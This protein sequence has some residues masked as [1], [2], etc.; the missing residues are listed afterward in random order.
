[1][2]FIVTVGICHLPIG[3]NLNA[4]QKFMSIDGFSESKA[5]QHATDLALEEIGG[6]DL[7]R[8]YAK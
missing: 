8:L 4:E 7:E 2:G 3:Y 5:L 6:V 1:M